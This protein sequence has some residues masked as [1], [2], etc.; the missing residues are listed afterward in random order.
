MNLKDELESQIED[1]RQGIYATHIHGQDPDSMKQQYTQ[2]AHQLYQTLIAP[3]AHLLSEEVLIIPD[4]KLAYIPF[5]MLLT[6]ETSPE[7][8]YADYPFL[9]KEKTISYAFSAT[10]WLEM[11]EKIHARA[12][13]HSLLA[14]A[15]TYLNLSPTG[16]FAS[17]EQQ[18][19]EYL[20]PLLYNQEEAQRIRQLMNGTEMLDTNATRQA[21]LDEAGDYQ[22]L[23]LAT[24]GKIND[25]SPNYSFLAFYGPKDS[26]FLEDTIQQGISGLFLA[27]LYNL[28][29][30]A[31]MVVLSACETGVGKLYRGEGIA[32][33]AR[34]FTYAG[35][36]S[37][38]TTLWQVNDKETRT[39][40]EAFYTYL[41]EGHSKSDALRQAKL[42]MIQS[43]EKLADPFF[44]AP[45][46]GMGDMRPLE[47]N[48]NIYGI[49]WGIA[50]ILLV[51]LS[52]VYLRRRRK[53]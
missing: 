9:I 50:G 13:N 39:F 48:K 21:F 20:G 1:L 35:A 41:K 27:D 52:I 40:M 7:T 4:G 32:S 38:I 44:W 31:D 43:S 10:L 2:A 29:L 26:L 47:W 36:K 12:A 5:E 16:L 53:S 11:R 8:P 22:I 51:I 14:V 25:A 17:A 46:V 18:R 49:G 15:P 42:D 34:G 33:L 28:Q 6:Q 19:G 30:N 45:Y 23:H 37:I 3:I 24:H